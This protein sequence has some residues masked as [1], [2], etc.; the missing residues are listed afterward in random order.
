VNRTDSGLPICVYPSGTAN[1]L[2]QYLALR[3]DPL[4][5]SKVIDDGFQ[6]KLDAGLANGRVFLVNASCGFDADVVRQVH[7]RREE[8]HSG[9]LSYWSYLKPIIRAIRSYQYPE[10]RVDLESAP[11]DPCSSRPDPWMV[12]WVFAFNLPLYGWGLPLAPWAHGTDGLLDVCTFRGGFFWNGLRYLVAAQGGWHRRLHDCGIGQA[13]RLRIS[14]E[15]PVAYQL[16]GDPG[17][18][19][20]LEIEVLPRRL[21]FVV[22]KGNQRRA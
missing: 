6:I 7:R 9:H 20:P 4:L 5:I 10:I 1:L 2:P 21:T 8:T 3:S 18:W 14:A 13:T 19:L 11:T 22:P 16:D 15:Q 12:R 17:G